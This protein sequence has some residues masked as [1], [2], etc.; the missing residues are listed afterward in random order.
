[1]SLVPFIGL[2]NIT[3]RYSYLASIGLIFI[4]IIVAKKLYEYLLI[5]GKNIAIGAVAVLVLIFALF[6]TIQIQQTYS[7][8]QDAGN[9]AK[10]FF[11]SLEAQY[12]DYWSGEDVQF[13]FVDVP[14]KFGEAWIFPVGL[15]DAVWFAFKN[16]NAKVFQHTDLKEAI[17]QAGSSLSHPVFKFNAD[18]SVTEVD[19]FQ[20]GSSNLINPQE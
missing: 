7:E 14:I 18:G 16:D 11:I 20:N 4:F 1:V 13:H 17:A 10:N 19:R 5:N 8:W 15:S 6:H 9:K 12:N 3:S 2:G